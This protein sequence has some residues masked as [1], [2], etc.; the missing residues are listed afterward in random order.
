M[1][2]HSHTS[3]FGVNT[4][5]HHTPP[6]YCLRSSTAFASNHSRIQPS[7]LVTLLP[8]LPNLPVLWMSQINVT[9]V[10]VLDNPAPFTAP[11]RF[12][13]T[14]ECYPPGLDDELEWK[15]I[16][17]GSAD[18]L[19]CDQEL[20]SVLVSPVSVGKNVFVFEAPPPNPALIPEKDLM[21]VTVLLLSALYRE[22]EFIRIGYYVNNEYSAEQ[23][24][25]KAEWDAYKAALDFRLQQEQAEL[26]RKQELD[27][28]QAA[29]AA[30]A[31]SPSAPVTPPPSS[32]PIAIPPL[33]PLPSI[34]SSCL[35][36]NILS[37]QPRVTRFQIAWDDLG[38]ARRL[39]GFEMEQEDER[40]AK[41]EEAKG[42]DAA[43]QDGDA[44]RDAK[45]R[46]VEGAE[47]G[48]EEKG[49]D[50]VE[51]EDDSDDDEDEDDEEADGGAA[52]VSG[53]EELR[54]Q[55]Q[56]ANGHA[57]RTAHLLLLFLSP[58][59]LNA[60]AAAVEA[61]YTTALGA[62]FTPLWI[63]SL[64]CNALNAVSPLGLF[65]LSACQKPRVTS[66]LSSVPLPVALRLH[67]ARPHPHLRLRPQRFPN[68]QP[69]RLQVPFHPPHPRPRPPSLPPLP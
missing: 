28:Y 18:D 30:P 22:R 1:A 54:E 34:Q 43:P 4:T 6:N 48:K 39:D 53:D 20:D 17:V 29:H 58:G 40:R 12:K 55:K 31:T 24:Q 19:S 42:V 63:D 57:A 14:F 44:A 26:L 64:Y 59:V 32:E 45:R 61:T 47:G 60:A 52:D 50:G 36:R 56:P 7:L 25:L 23:P 46:R 10:E 65:R 8:S 35:T 13:V 49:D 5:N 21:E 38:T 11:F 2:L 33:P 3:A 37:D 9:N 16:Y 15:L 69:E 62:L 66:H 27:D 68:L 51:E 67:S 41:E